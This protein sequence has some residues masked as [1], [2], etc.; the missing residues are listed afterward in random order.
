MSDINQITLVGRVVRDAVQK[1]ANSGTAICE[2]SIAYD[3]YNYAKKEDEASFIDVTLFGRQAEALGRYL[4]KGQQIAVS[5][6]LRQDRWQNQD[7]QNRSKHVVIGQNI[8]LLRRPKN[9]DETGENG[10]RQAAGPSTGTN[11]PDRSDDGPQDGFG[12]DDFPDGI[13]F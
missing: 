10:P 2:L 7:G 1:Y 12:A 5:G 13:P 9:A 4:V 8:Q 3:V 6:I 11:Y